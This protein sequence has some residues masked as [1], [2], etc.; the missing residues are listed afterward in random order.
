LFF[1]PAWLELDLFSQIAPVVFGPVVATLALVG[2][3]L[4]GSRLPW[5][6]RLRVLLAIIVTGGIGP[7]GTA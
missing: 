7:L 1:V 2:W 3:W 4:F 6:D 5:T